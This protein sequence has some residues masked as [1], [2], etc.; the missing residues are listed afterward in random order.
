MYLLCLNHL[1]YSHVPRLGMISLICGKYLDTLGEQ[2]TIGIIYIT[3][4]SITLQ[5]L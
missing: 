3:S 2:F 5:Y 4:F 1:A